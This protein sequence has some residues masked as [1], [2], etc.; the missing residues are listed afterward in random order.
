MRDGA[1]EQRGNGVT[2]Q[3]AKVQRCKVQGAGFKGAGCKVQG[4][5]RFKEIGNRNRGLEV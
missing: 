4:F 2:V 3:G 5:P 1:A